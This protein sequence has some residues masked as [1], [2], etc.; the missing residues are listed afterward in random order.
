MMLPVMQ[1]PIHPS[2]TWSPAEPLGT[3][4]LRMIRHAPLDVWSHPHLGKFKLQ[5]FAR[6]TKAYRD[7]RL[8]NGTICPHRGADLRGEARRRRLCAMP[9]AFPPL[10][11][12]DWPAGSC[13]SCGR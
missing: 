10:E 8:V 2:A 3:K 11:P 13:L 7:A 6:L 5:G 12:R 9:L 1:E 4:Q